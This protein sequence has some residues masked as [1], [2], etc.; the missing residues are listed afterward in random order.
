MTVVKAL[1]EKKEFPKKDTNED[2]AALIA[3]LQS[4]ATTRIKTVRLKK[5][6]ERMTKTSTT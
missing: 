3:S 4:I 1:R 5:S 2:V 6:D